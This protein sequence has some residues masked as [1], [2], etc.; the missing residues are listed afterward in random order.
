MVDQGAQLADNRD[1]A[2]NIPV[3]P[4]DKEA[5]KYYPTR[6][7]RSVVGNQPYDTY[8]PWM[9]FLQL[10]TVQAHRSVLEA[11]H[12]LRTTKDEQ[13]MATTSSTDLLKDM[14]DDT[15]HQNSLEMT[16]TSED[17]ITVWAHLMTQCN[18]MPGLKKFGKQGKTA[19]VKELMQ[20]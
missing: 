19:T 7:C 10:G 11:S 3:V 17:K 8:A 18:L 6:A 5:G 4:E 13:M 9:A 16:T 15:I 1:D 2:I 14:I 20:S 12:L